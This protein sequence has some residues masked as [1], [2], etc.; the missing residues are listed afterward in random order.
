MTQAGAG[1]ASLDGGALPL[2]CLTGSRVYDVPVERPINHSCPR[3]QRALPLSHAVAQ[4][5]A[6]ILVLGRFLGR[7]WSC[8]NRT[9]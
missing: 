5:D 3:R 2:A 8:I 7:S 4:C 6:E 9:R 1:A